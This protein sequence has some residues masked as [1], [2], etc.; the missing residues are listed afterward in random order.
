MPYFFLI[1]I[2]FQFQAQETVFVESTQKG[3]GILKSRSGECFVITPEHVVSEDASV[4]SIIGSKN[5]LSKGELVQS[6]GEGIDLA[7]VRV[8][9]GGAQNCTNWSVPKNYTSMLNNSIDA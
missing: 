2:V 5:V 9:G 8:V 7:I 4:L 1:V 3:K 6:Y